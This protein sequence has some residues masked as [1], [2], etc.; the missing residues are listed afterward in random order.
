MPSPVSG[1]GEKDSLIADLTLST[2]ALW[3]SRSPVDS[4]PPYDT[5]CSLPAVFLALPFA[6]C[7]LLRR[8]HATMIVLTLRLDNLRKSAVKY[9]L[10]VCCPVVGSL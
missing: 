9:L 8:R 2:F 10:F 1:A 5:Y 6:L 7:S 3:L 4:G